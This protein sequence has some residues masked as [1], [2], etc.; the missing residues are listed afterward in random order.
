MDEYAGSVF[1]PVSLHKYL[2]ANANPVMFS[3]PSGYR[4]LAELTTVSKCMAVLSESYAAATTAVLKFAS[5]LLPMLRAS[6]V[7][8][9]MVAPLFFPLASA[10]EDTCDG[11]LNGNETSSSVG[12]GAV[13]NVVCDAIPDIFDNEAEQDIADDKHQSDDRIILYHYTNEIG[14]YGILSTGFIYPSLQ[15]NN[16]KDA[17]YGNGVYLSDIIPNTATPTQLARIFINVPNKYKYT[18]YI[19]IDVTDM[20]VMPCRP[21]VYLAPGNNN[22]YIRDRIVGFGKVG[23]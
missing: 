1:E 11:L 21:G 12:A 10:L 23:V 2:Y 19:A 13:D 8:G 18:H 3:D 15:K 9:L 20:L 16:P 5:G 14:M 22:F 6:V 17:R 4:T 7:V